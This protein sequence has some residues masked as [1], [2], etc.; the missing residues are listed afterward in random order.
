MLEFLSV[1]RCSHSCREMLAFLTSIGRIKFCTIKLI[2]YIGAER[3]RYSVFDIHLV[4]NF[5]ERKY[6]IDVKIS[7]IAFTK[8]AHFTLGEIR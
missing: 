3:S 1:E 4:F 8:D 5:E 6:Q 7:T 2:D